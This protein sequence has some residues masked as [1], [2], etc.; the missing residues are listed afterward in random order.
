VR[1][2]VN[3]V[4]ADPAEKRRVALGLLGAHPGTAVAQAAFKRLVGTTPTLSAPSPVGRARGG[5][6]LA[7]DSAVGEWLRTRAGIV[8]QGPR[9][10]GYL[11]DLGVQTNLDSAD[12]KFRA[13]VQE[14]LA[15]ART[16]LGQRLADLPQVPLLG[17]DMPPPDRAAQLADIAQRVRHDLSQFR[18]YAQKAMSTND[19][20]LADELVSVARANTAREG[21]HWFKDPD[22]SVL[23][24]SSVGQGP[25]GLVEELQEFFLT[26]K[27]AAGEVNAILS[28]LQQQE[29]AALETA[30]ADPAA[31]ESLPTL[32][33][34]RAYPWLQGPPA[35]AD[36]ADVYAELV[37]LATPL[38]DAPGQLDGAGTRISISAID[39]EKLGNRQFAG[40]RG[41][42]GT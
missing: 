27:G 2:T 10:S 33:L 13:T 17:T 15:D 31:A 8:G 32:L 36:P 29:L 4:G 9:G 19:R 38:T 16:G 30:L 37:R 11:S 42:R 12:A 40:D 41:P 3:R 6:A 26:P 25:P 24:G 23:M 14:L 18:D 20:A 7:P 39:A 28:V 22:Y 35:D 5:T 34:N 21:A 1:P